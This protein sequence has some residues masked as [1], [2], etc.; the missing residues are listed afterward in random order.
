MEDIIYIETSSPR[1]Q[2]DRAIIYSPTIDLSSLTN[3]ELSFST[4]MYGNEIDSLI[5]DI[6]N[7][8]GSSYTN[9]FTKLG[10]QGNQW[11]DESV[12]LSIY[13]GDVQFRITGTRGV[14]WAGDITIDNFK[15]SEATAC[16]S[17]A[18]ALNATN[19][20]TTSAD[21]SWTAGNANSHSLS[22]DGFNG[23]N[24]IIN[25]LPTSSNFRTHEFYLYAE[26]HSPNINQQGVIFHSQ[27]YSSNT[28][29]GEII[30]FDGD[31][32]FNIKLDSTGILDHIVIG[33]LSKNMSTINGIILLLNLI[34]MEQLIFTLMVF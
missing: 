11:N 29:W 23:D 24:L 25:G 10:D 4:H 17:F 13:S 5:I 1:A 8:S 9:I 34:Q 6:S 28:N 14:S 27:N 7:N 19:I 33:T 26:P 20:N 12:D 2:G 15:V 21:L 22:F 3:P 18:T 30:N 31:N 16:N 32:D